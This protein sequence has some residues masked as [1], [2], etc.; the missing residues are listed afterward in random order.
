MI[1]TNATSDGPVYEFDLSIFHDTQS[2]SVVIQT[3]RNIIISNKSVSQI[4]SFPQLVP[5]RQKIATD[6]EV[7]IYKK[8]SLPTDRFQ[9][10]LEHQ[11]Q[12]EFSYTL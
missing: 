11:D 12:N 8:S 9:L 6:K 2:V 3:A 7:K 5:P 1:P 4:L 10:S